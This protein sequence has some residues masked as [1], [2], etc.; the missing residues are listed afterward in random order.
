MERVKKEISLKTNDGLKI[1]ID[2]GFACSGEVEIN[3]FE[4]ASGTDCNLARVNLEDGERTISVFLDEHINN[5]IV[6]GFGKASPLPGK[7]ETRVMVT[8]YDNDEEI[9]KFDL[10]ENMFKF[11]LVLKEKKEEK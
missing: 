2:S 4:M 6:S 5:Y 7:T 9:D 10:K 8:L 3:L 1:K 11:I